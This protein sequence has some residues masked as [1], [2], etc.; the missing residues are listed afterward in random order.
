MFQAL[1]ICVLLWVNGGQGATDLTTTDRATGSDVVEAVV[2][3]I[4]Q[5]CIFD[6]DRLLLRRIAHVET[7]D[8]TANNTFMYAGNYFYGG[9]WQVN[10]CLYIYI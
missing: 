1:I 9:I 7:Q 10:M 8:G 2:D 5:S 4:H 3:L 6:N